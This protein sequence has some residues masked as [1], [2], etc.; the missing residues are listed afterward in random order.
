MLLTKL[1]SRTYSPNPVGADVSAP[2]ISAPA[3]SA[4]TIS[5][6]A[7]IQQFSSILSQPISQLSIA[8]LDRR[9][10]QTICTYLS[11]EAAHAQVTTSGDNPADITVEAIAQEYAKTCAL[12]WQSL[13]ENVQPSILTHQ[14]QRLCLIWATHRHRSLIENGSRKNGSRKNGSRKNA[15]KETLTSTHSLQSQ[16]RSPLIQT[17]LATATAQ[18]LSL[19]SEI[20]IRHYSSS[21]AYLCGC[22]MNQLLQWNHQLTPQTLR[23]LFS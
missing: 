8:Q 2:A 18:L 21:W 12:L 11:P 4:Q 6:P 5:A 19:P 20:S 3:V 22:S 10:D 16:W 14:A 23:A 13:S 9:I 15:L 17:A 7:H 1:S